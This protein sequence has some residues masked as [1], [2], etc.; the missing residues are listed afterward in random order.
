M[1]YIVDTIHWV[2]VEVPETEARIA[3]NFLVS[4]TDQP[5]YRGR[6]GVDNSDSFGFARWF[7]NRDAAVRYM[8]EKAEQHIERKES[9]LEALE[10]QVHAMRAAILRAD[11]N[12]T[13]ADFQDTLI[14]ALA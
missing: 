4:E 13:A 14:E 12:K 8:G 7:P 10:S 1:F 11:A 3:G 9:E 6:Y 2:M 5:L